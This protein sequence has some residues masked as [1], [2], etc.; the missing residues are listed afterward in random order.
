ML[1]NFPLDGLNERCIASAVNSFANLVHWHQS[2]NLA[3]QIVLVNVHTS[4]RIPFSI[5]VAAGDELYAH[6]WSVVCYVLT[7]TQLPPPVEPE[8]APVNGRTPHPLP[9]TPL[10]WMGAGSS[11]SARQG[12]GIGFERVAS[13]G[14][15]HQEGPRFMGVQA[16]A[17]NVP[18]PA[19]ALSVIQAGPPRPPQRTGVQLNFEVLG[20]F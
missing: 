1:V 11:V 10:R 18:T 7:E 16:G 19:Q 12:R 15:H 9:A 13:S 5:V 20:F 3:R 2:S 14:R 6:C 17:S 4:A 8:P